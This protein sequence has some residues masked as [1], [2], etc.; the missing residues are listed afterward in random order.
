M[1]NF[2]VITL[3]M[4][5]GLSA[6]A[7]AEVAVPDKCDSDVHRH[8]A[9]AV[10]H[11]DNWGE[12]LAL[13]DGANWPCALEASHG[14]YFLEFPEPWLKIEYLMKKHNLRENLRQYIGLEKGFFARVQISIWILTGKSPFINNA[15]FMSRIA[16]YLAEKLNVHV[17][18]VHLSLG[19]V[20]YVVTAGAILCC[21]CFVV[22]HSHQD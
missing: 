2:I 13:E 8:L 14:S 21:F 12:K 22:T 15:G 20:Q 10:I 3:L 16:E 9:I 17:L 5:F 4:S 1:K 19:L 6:F 11:D 18:T 7:D